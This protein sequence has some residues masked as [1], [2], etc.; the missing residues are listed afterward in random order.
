MGTEILR[1]QDCLIKQTIF[2]PA[3]INQY[4][5]RGNGYMNP[6]FGNKKSPVKERRFDN[7]GVNNNNN[8]NNCNLVIGRVRI[9]KR[10][11]SPQIDRRINMLSTDP[12]I[13]QKKIRLEDLKDDGGSVNIEFMADIYAG[14]AF[15]MSP[16]PRSLP[17]PSFFNKI[18]ASETVDDSATRDLRRLLR[19]E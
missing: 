11:E 1:P 3:T 15:S 18:Q 2:S 8:N 19:L 17:L 9:L 13:V 4:R 14:S 10:G 6:R 7:N 16:S 12:L 5:K